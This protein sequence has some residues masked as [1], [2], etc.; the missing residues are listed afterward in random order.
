MIAGGEGAVSAAV[1]TALKEYGTVLRDGGANRY[2]TSVLVAKRFFNNPDKAVLAYAMNFP[3]GLSGG[4]L[5]NAIGAPL[6]LT[7]SKKPDAAIEYAGEKN[8]G[9]GYVLGGITLI[10]DEAVVD[11]FK[12]QSADEIVVKE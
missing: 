12:L 1:E 10:S 3:D 4:V 9:S 6:I 7:D 2:E 8:I 11:I 5:A